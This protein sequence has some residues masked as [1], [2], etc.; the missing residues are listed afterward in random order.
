[1]R[2]RT[3]PRRVDLCRCFISW[4]A[5]RKERKEIE[6]ER[7]EVRLGGSAVTSPPSGRPGLLI[8]VILFFASRRVERE[9]RGKEGGG[10]RLKKSKRVLQ[11]REPMPISCRRTAGAEKGGKREGG[12]EGKTDYWTPLAQ[13]DFII[14]AGKKRKERNRLITADRPAGCCPRSRCATR[15]PSSEG[16]K[17]RK[18]GGERREGK[19]S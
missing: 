13:S 15:S 9:R 6:R 10:R 18:R 7:E 1:M 4:A 5:S 2:K 14:T 8:W 12:E 16:R 11:P 17:K 3:D 19:T